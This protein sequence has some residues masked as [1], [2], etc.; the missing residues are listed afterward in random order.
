MRWLKKILARLDAVAD[1]EHGVDAPDDQVV[2]RLPRRPAWAAATNE[3]HAQVA[4][5]LSR[6]GE[7][8]EVRSDIADVDE[9][10]RHL[11]SPRLLAVGI[12]VLGLGEFLAASLLLGG[13]GLTGVERFV[14][15]ALL[16]GGL[17]WLT[18]LVVEGMPPADRPAEAAPPTRW[19]LLATGYAILVIA[20]AITRSATVEADVEGNGLVRVAY[21][22]VLLA[23]TI[24]PAFLIKTWLRDRRPAA[25]LASRRR[26][27]KQRERELARTVARAEAF[28]AS[29]ADRADDW[30]QAADQLR[31]EYRH[32]HR[33]TA[34]SAALPAKR[35]KP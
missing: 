33:L 5:A 17:V 4:A 11:S 34:G 24:G 10:L 31:T 19:R 20:L 32:T 2:R 16:T 30:D 18:G 15:S 27:L 13:I 35:R 7:L 12:V 8:D 22:T 25:A 14:L 21:S 6:A 28:T 1:A 26:A 3:R 23:L 29:L 9:Q